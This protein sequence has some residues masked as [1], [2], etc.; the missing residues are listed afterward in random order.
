MGGESYVSPNGEVIAALSDKNIILISR[1]GAKYFPLPNSN[2][3]IKDYLKDGRILLVDV[4]NRKD[5]Y[6]EN[7][8][9]TDIYY[10]FNPLTGETTKNSIFLPDLDTGRNG[11]SFTI[12]YSSDMKYVL[13]RS[14]HAVKESKYYVDKFTLYDLIRNKAIWVGPLR[15]ANLINSPDTV[16]GWQPNTNNLTA[17]YSY[18]DT[19]TQNYF[20]ISLDGKISPLTNFDGLIFLGNITNPIPSEWSGWAE[21]PNW[22]PNGR[23]LIFKGLQKEDKPSFGYGTFMYIWDNQEKIGYKPCLPDER[24]ETSPTRTQWSFDGS[25]AIMNLTFGGAGQYAYGKSYLL[26]LGNKIIYEMPD[27]SQKGFESAY[28]DG[29]NALLGWVNWESP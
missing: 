17:L 14:K 28:R 20:S 27:D 15:E 5:S 22:S 2:V 6:K 24:E 4:Q 19:D 21:S 9:L 7:V 3:F 11:Y 8:G 26:D 29:Y 25:Y 13:Y 12:Q 18:M 1:D 16:L 10:I 23:Y